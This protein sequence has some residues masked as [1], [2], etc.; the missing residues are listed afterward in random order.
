MSIS[1]QVRGVEAAKK[2]LEELKQELTDSVNQ[3]NSESITHGSCTYPVEN[4]KI[5]WNRN[6]KL[7]EGYA[8]M[9]STT[10][11]SFSF[12][13]KYRTGDFA[14][15][16]E[17][18]APGK[19][20]IISGHNTNVEVPKL[21][22]EGF[23]FRS[24]FDEITEGDT[25][26]WVYDK[27]AVKMFEAPGPGETEYRGMYS[28][29]SHG[30]LA[31]ASGSPNRIEAGQVVSMS[32]E[33]A[34]EGDTVWIRV[35]SNP[36]A[37][38]PMFQFP[39]IEN[40]MKDIRKMKKK[41]NSWIT[42]EEKTGHWNRTIVKAMSGNKRAITKMNDLSDRSVCIMG[43]AF[44]GDLWGTHGNEPCSA[45][46]TLGTSLLH[47][48]TRPTEGYGYYP[49]VMERYEEYKMMFEW[50]WNNAHAGH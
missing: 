6:L 11:N 36:M 42:F 19:P 32:T 22:F 17:S 40:I 37:M 9:M 16:M 5:E 45:C 15:V 3:I 28:R 33:S 14:N 47:L 10:T 30:V 27:N 44:G 8:N 39:A 18:M 43:K 29:N 49:T 23:D 24:I 21:E 35:S 31:R 38:T 20:L 50:H 7:D 1:I 4:M 34:S 25:T 46:E 12:D 13:V 41:Y 26:A 2:R 48:F